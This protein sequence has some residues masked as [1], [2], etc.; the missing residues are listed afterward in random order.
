MPATAGH[1]DAL[2]SAVHGVSHLTRLQPDQRILAVP[3]ATLPAA[4]SLGRRQPLLTPRGPLGIEGDFLLCHLVISSRP[5][6]AAKGSVVKTARIVCG[7]AALSWA[8]AS[9]P[10][11]AQRVQFATP[12]ADAGRSAGCGRVRAARRSVALCSPPLASAAASGATSASRRGARSARRPTHRRP[13]GVVAVRRLR[14]TPLQP[15]PANWDPYATP[16]NTPSALV[17]ARPVFPIGGPPVSMA[18]VQKFVQ[19]V[20]LDY[21]WFAGHNGQNRHKNWASTTWN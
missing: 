12:F 17:A 13:A 7:L 21:H 20:D 9:L 3:T 16:G 8:L 10:A 2:P 15:P 19:H 4:I 18:T 11:L 6:Q 14:G 5:L 1:A